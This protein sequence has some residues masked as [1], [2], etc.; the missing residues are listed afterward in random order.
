MWFELHTL[1]CRF[2][3]SIIN[4]QLLDLFKWHIFQWWTFRTLWGLI[5]PSNGVSQMQK[6]ENLLIGQFHEVQFSLQSGHWVYC[7]EMIH[8]SPEI[9]LYFLIIHKFDRNKWPELIFIIF[10]IE[11][12]KLCLDLLFCE[13]ISFNEDMKSFKNNMEIYLLFKDQNYKCQFYSFLIFLF[14]RKYLRSS[15]T[16]SSILFWLVCFNFSVSSSL[17]YSR[18]WR[19][20]STLCDVKI[21]F[22][23]SK[24]YFI[25]FIYYIVLYSAV[26]NLWYNLVY[27]LSLFWITKIIPRDRL[28]S[29][30]W[31]FVQF[32]LACRHIWHL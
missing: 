3:W 24:T 31:K 10:I 6:R 23:Y 13:E 1:E 22:T 11:S 17:F 27:N 15:L 7:P 29:E 25:R 12:I 30:F 18:I 8:Y 21:Y 5:C 20:G 2:Q 9:L 14:S 26:A 32:L 4:F 16:I 28:S 19:E